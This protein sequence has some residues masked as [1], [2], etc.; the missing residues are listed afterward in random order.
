MHGEVGGRPEV[1]VVLVMM[2]YQL[3]HLQQVDSIIPSVKINQQGLS[4]FLILYNIINSIG[5]ITDEYVRPEA[6]RALPSCCVI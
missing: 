2:L 1:L 3:V 4:L 6:E 5:Q